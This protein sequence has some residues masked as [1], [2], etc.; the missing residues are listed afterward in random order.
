MT[1]S[2]SQIQKFDRLLGVNSD[3]RRDADRINAAK[4]NNE[5]VIFVKSATLKDRQA[6]DARVWARKFIR[7]ED[8]LDISSEIE[9]SY[10]RSLIAY[11]ND[12]KFTA[13]ELGVSKE[14]IDKVLACAPKLINTD[15]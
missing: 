7:R 12:F 4:N 5:K 13:K 11:I 2:K 14:Q 1:F 3:M 8:I 10:L 9:R 6:E 15:D